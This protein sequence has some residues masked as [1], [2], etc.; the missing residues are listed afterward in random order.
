LRAIRR[1]ADLSAGALELEALPGLTFLA[2]EI[3]RWHKA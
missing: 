1:A 2:G 3:V